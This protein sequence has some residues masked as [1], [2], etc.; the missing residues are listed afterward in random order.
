IQTKKHVKYYRLCLNMLPTQFTSYDSSRISIIFFCLAGLDLLG[1]LDHLEPSKRQ[2][3]A[4][5][6]WRFYVTNGEGFRGSTSMEINSS[7]DYDPAHLASTY[8]ALS[9]LSTLRDDQVKSKLNKDKI[10][11][12]ISR[13]QQPNGSFAP[14]IDSNGNAIGEY[15]MRYCYVAVSCCVLLG[16]RPDSMP[17]DVKRLHQYII[18][19]LN[20][21]G[22][23]SQTPQCESHAGLTYCALASLWMCGVLNQDDWSNTAAWLAF[24]Q[25]PLME[26]KGEGSDNSGGFNGRV[27]KPADTCYSFWVIGSLSIL[28]KIGFINIQKSKG[29]LLL[30]TQNLL[31]GGFSKH[32]GSLPDPLHSYLGLCAL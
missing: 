3:W 10:L 1:D 27:N 22:G 16:C 25:I 17:F 19:C 18:S 28:E 20:Y 26:D 12:Y 8:F 2:E 14:C 7:C 31:M 9:I 21:D 29:F 4:N 30:G 32:R 11:S 23:I 5:E 15:D 24:R 6:I 13:C